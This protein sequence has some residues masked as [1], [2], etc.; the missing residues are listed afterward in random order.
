MLPCLF[1]EFLLS[2]IPIVEVGEAVEIV[3]RFQKLL[4]LLRRP[5]VEGNVSI[6]CKTV[7]EHERAVVGQQKMKTERNDRIVADA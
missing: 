5:A 4:F 6:L 2:Q 1:V 7:I 3:Q